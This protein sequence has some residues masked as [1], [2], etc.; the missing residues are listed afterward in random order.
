MAR[1]AERHQAVELEVRAPLGALDD[2]VD[3]DDPLSGCCVR[4]QSMMIGTAA[5]RATIIPAEG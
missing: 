3:V 5:A 2:V 1:R 4:G